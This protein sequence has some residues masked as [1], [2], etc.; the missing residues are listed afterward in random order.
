MWPAA[1]QDMKITARRGAVGKCQAHHLGDELRNEAS[2]YR[3][4]RTVSLNGAGSPSPILWSP[5]L[6]L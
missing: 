5:I 1:A 6:Q 3:C 4:L 2:A